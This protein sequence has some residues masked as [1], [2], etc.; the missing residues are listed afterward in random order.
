[1][2]GLSLQ[3]CGNGFST[4]DGETPRLQ[5]D[6]GTFAKNRRDTLQRDFDISKT[7]TV[8]DTKMN[9][10]YTDPAIV[11]VHECTIART[12]IING[13]KTIISQFNPGMQT[14]KCRVFKNKITGWI[15]SA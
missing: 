13:D 12:V 15:T 1:M 8:T 4:P 3:W 6:T 14:G 7:D 11:A 5:P 2:V 10:P 9:P